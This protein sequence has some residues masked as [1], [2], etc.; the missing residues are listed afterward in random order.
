[1]APQNRRGRHG[2]VPYPLDGIP[3]GTT[4]KQLQEL[5]NGAR[6]ELLR[7]TQEEDARRIR[8]VEEEEER[9]RVAEEE[10]EKRRVE[11]EEERK[12]VKEEERRKAVDEEE[13]RRVAQEQQERETDEE[14]R[15]QKTRRKQKGKAKSRV[16]KRKWDSL[17]GPSKRVR[18]V[19]RDSRDEG[20]V[21]NPYVTCFFLS[22]D[23]DL[24]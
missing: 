19:T 11:E 10:A 2:R 12:R 24:V 5:I 13:A 16:A 15:T 17:P 7:L 14:T 8:E 20:E 18:G 3:E 6:M 23:A 22:E 21:N 4:A 9:R 1:M